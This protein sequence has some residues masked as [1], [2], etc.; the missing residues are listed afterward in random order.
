MARAKAATRSTKQEAFN[1]DEHAA[2]RAEAAITIGG[3]EFHRR[4]KNHGVTREARTMEQ[5]QERLNARIRHA[6]K[7]IVEDEELSLEERERQEDEISKMGDEAM[8]VTYDLV[9]LLLVDGEGKSPQMKLL[10]DKL[11]VEELAALSQA[12]LGGGEPAEGPTQT[13]NS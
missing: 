7:Q 10:H 1:A 5:K 11:D 12:L 3:Q 2:K 9:A 6:E 8:Q 13:P 4:L